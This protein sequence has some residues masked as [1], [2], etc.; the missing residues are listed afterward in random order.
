MSAWTFHNP[1]DLRFG[2]GTFDTIG[3]VVGG[4]RYLLVTH[5]DVVFASLACGLDALSHALE[6]NWN[7]NA[8]PVTR[9]YAR[10][11]AGDILTALPRLKSDLDVLKA[12]ALLSRGATFAGL[13]FS[14]TM[15]ALAHNISYPVTL[16]K[17]V[18]HGIACSFTLPSVMKAAIGIDADC[19]ATI[20]TRAMRGNG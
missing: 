11:A 7:R 18:V 12:C 2:E 9:H 6:S 19:D 1:V 4:R 20:E 16:Q 17:G 14:N 5:P 3:Q 8:N 10:M 13:A 15:T